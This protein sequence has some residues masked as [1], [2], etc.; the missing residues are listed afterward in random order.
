MPAPSP[1][2]VETSSGDTTM[3]E[4]DFNKDRL[5]LALEAAGLDLWEND[6]V[7]GDVTRRALK[8]FAELGYNEEETFKYMN[9]MFAIVH[10]DDAPAVK[11]AINE[12]LTGATPQYRCEFRLLAKN[13]S[14][15]WFANYGKIMK[16]SG[17][18]HGKRFIGVTFNIND[19]KCQEEELRRINL[20]L[21]EQNQQFEKMNIALQSLSTSDPLTRLSNRRLLLERL[22]Q[23]LVSRMRTGQAGALLFIDIDDFKTLNDTLGHDR[24][25]L[26]LQQVAKRLQSCVRETDTIARIGGDE[27]VVMMEHLSK[28]PMEAAAQTEAVGEKIREALS[29]TY[30]LD[31]YEYHGSSSIGATLFNRDS[32]TVEELIKQTDIAMYQAKKAGRNTVRF[33]DPQMQAAIDARTSL[34]ADLR[35]AIDRNEFQLFYQ[36]KVDGL[37]QPIGA[38][39]LIRW[40]HPERGLMLP[41]QFIPLAEETG[42]IQPIGQWVLETACSQLKIWQ[43]NTRTH[44]LVLSVNISAKQFRQTDFVGQVKAVLQRYA[45]DPSLLKLELTEGMLLDNVNDIV[46]A[47]NTL[48]EIGVKF[49]LDDFGKGYSSLQY[50]KQLPLDQLK[51]DRS[52]VHDLVDDNNDK[53]IVRTIIAMARSLNLEVIAEG[54]E[55]EAQKNLLKKKGC[56]IFQG[57]LFG[58]P[59]PIEQFET[60]LTLV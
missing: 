46:A 56:E 58:K 42:L 60:L 13:G 12:H 31:S 15:V 55:T 7:S 6:L 43:K 17:V 29:L 14:W 54:V 9:D 38:E 41:S 45:I 48:N 44:H 50:L 39:G 51:I 36:I 30:Q 11:V 49:S 33:F 16:S 34:E 57:Y 19:R 37:F 40:I 23:A 32:Q 25:D 59:V 4:E 10:P 1:I 26:M 27:F 53:A 28:T 2:L 47:M 18:E 21:A 24:G 20:K 52:F 8:T 5:E 35:K 22:Q 3:S